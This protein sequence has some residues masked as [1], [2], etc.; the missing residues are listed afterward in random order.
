[1][2]SRLTACMTLAG[3]KT[4]KMRSSQR[5]T[6]GALPRATTHS[7]SAAWQEHRRL[8]WVSTTVSMW[9]SNHIRSYH[10][11]KLTTFS[12]EKW[13]TAEGRRSMQLQSAVVQ[14]YRGLVYRLGCTV[15]YM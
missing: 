3:V 10:C 12:N 15:D 14:V 13:Q 4:P 5:G 1:M 6:H 11:T 8:A 7:T 9:F 2:G